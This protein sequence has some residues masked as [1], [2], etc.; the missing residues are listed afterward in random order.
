VYT[1][2][3]FLRSPASAVID[4]NRDRLK[5]TGGTVGCF[6]IGAAQWLRSDAVVTVMQPANFWTGDNATD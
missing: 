1:D 6:W 4:R 3:L 2:Q 5:R